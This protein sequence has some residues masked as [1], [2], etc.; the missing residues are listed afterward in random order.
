MNIESDLDKWFSRWIRIRN[1]TD[2]GRV[3]CCTCGNA[4]HFDS[5]LLQCGHFRRRRFRSTRWDE[6]NCSAQCF[7]CNT[8]EDGAEDRH[9]K[10]I[11][12]TWGDGTADELTIKS[13]QPGKFHE[14]ELKEMRDYYRDKVKAELKK[15]GLN[16]W[17]S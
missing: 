1:A 6:R 9:A 15:R 14:W 7:E 8:Y 16:I 4:Y 2:Q 10:Y 3:F 17:R 13:H 5:T 11:D 12:R